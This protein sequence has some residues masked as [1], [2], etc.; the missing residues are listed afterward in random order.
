MYCVYAIYNKNH[1]K[2]YI[3]QTIDLG[4]RIVEH[5]DFNNSNHAYTKRFDGLWNVI[6]TETVKTRKDALVREKQL[7]SYR[8][9]QFIKSFIPR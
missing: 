9:R 5:N 7:K 3:G 1:G 4:K 6:Y 2:I 8:G